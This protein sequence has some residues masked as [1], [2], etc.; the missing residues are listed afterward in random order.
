MRTRSLAVA[1]ISAGLLVGGAAG[2]TLT[3]PGTAGA[4]DVGDE[5]TTETTVDEADP[6]REAAAAERITEVLAPLVED[7]TITAEQADAVAA[8]LAA[9]LPGRGGPGGHHRR[10]GAGVALDVVAEV[11]GTD[12][13]AI[14]DAVADGTTVGELTDEAGV[15]R[16]V[17]IDALVLA[18]SERLDE[19]V[20]AGRLTREQA[21]EVIAR[22]TERL[23][24]LLDAEVPP[25]GPR[26]PGHHRGPGAGAPD[27]ETPD[28]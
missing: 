28:D 21:D 26:G 3:L 23:P 8:T 25:G 24:D 15:E 14:R 11:L 18:A 12:E 7:G 17:L 1:G 6:E 22:L 19:A 13:E 5:A 20:A 4:Q 9:E 16:R 10:A 2:L 27:A